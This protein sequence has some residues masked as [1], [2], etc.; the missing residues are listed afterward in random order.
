MSKTNLTGIHPFTLLDKFGVDSY[1][2]FFLR[3]VNYGQ[4]GNF[5]W[6]SMVERHNADLANGLGNLVSRILA[7][8]ASNYDGAV[9]RPGDPGAAGDLPAVVGDAVARYH[10]HMIAVRLTAGLGAVWDVI[11]RANQYLVEKEPWKLAKDEAQK[12]E[13]AGVLYASAELLR[14]L[15]ILVQP[16]M[17]SAAQ[18]LWDQLGLTGEVADQRL[19]GAAAWG[20]LA[21]GTV[22]SKGEALFPRLEPED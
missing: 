9:P 11:S 13:L 18:R 17:P 1:R 4:D 19:P 6:E 3:D 5:S 14:I 2:W 22:T 20:G 16:I 7:M 21:P 10:E 12:D 8:L 15:A